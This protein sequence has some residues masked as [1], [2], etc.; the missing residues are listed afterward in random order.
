MSGEQTK[1]M[2]PTANGAK[3]VLA[4][5]GTRVQLQ[6]DGTAASP[7]NVVANF[8]VGALPASG[9]WVR[10]GIICVKGI[11]NLHLSVLYNGHASSTTGAA[12]I[13]P[14]VCPQYTLPLSTDDVWDVPAVTDGSVTRAALATG[15]LPT[16]NVITRTFT[17]GKVNMNP[18]ALEVGPVTATSDKGRI[19]IDINVEFATYF[20]LYVREAGDTTNTGTIDIWYTGSV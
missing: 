14:F 9:A 6:C 1:H 18:L 15:T 12:E 4:S 20:M 11:R 10:S 7:F 17:Y 19:G 2:P 5:E 16:S 13:I 8:N 3:V